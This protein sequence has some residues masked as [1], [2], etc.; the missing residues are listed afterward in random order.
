MYEMCNDLG[1]GD[2]FELIFS[3]I[4]FFCVICDLLILYEFRVCFFDFINMFRMVVSKV[5][6]NRIK[7]FGKLFFK[8]IKNK[9]NVGCK[10]FVK[11]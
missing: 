9:I 4:E 3:V 11:G 6:F 7:K 1:I 10:L 8:V 2:Y 5:N